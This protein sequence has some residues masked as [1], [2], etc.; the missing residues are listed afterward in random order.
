[1]K[2]GKPTVKEAVEILMAAIR[3]ISNG[4]EYLA[5]GINCAAYQGFWSGWDY[6]RCSCWVKDARDYIVRAVN[7]SSS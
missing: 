2:D 4:N 6:A 7:D 3:E 5:H 1:M